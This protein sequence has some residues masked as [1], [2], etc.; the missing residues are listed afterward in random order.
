MVKPAGVPNIPPPTVNFLRRAKSKH[1]SCDSHT[2]RD[3]H[4]NDLETGVLRQHAE[5]ERSATRWENQTSSALSRLLRS[6]DPSDG[7]S[8]LKD[9]SSDILCCESECTTCTCSLRDEPSASGV[10]QAE[11][12]KSRLGETSRSII[13]SIKKA[14]SRT[15]KVLNTGVDGIAVGAGKAFDLT[16]INQLADVRA[17]ITLCTHHALPCMASAHAAPVVEQIKDRGQSR[18][19]N[20]L[21]EKLYNKVFETIGG[22]VKKTVC[23][24]SHA[25]RE[26]PSERPLHVCG[27]RRR[28][29]RT[30]PRLS[31][32]TWALL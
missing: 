10:C 5:T 23:S 8:R 26:A 19:K 20:Y 7:Y 29:R 14:G 18:V 28:C 24:S 6:G 30:C 27:A 32:S 9:D 1:A 22:I 16:G 31:S 17:R 12:S 21:N 4:T 15:G 11:S 3:A 2:S 25:G 13:R